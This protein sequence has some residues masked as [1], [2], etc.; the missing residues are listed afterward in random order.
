[1]LTRLGV[2]AKRPKTSI[3]P[4]FTLTSAVE[5]KTFSCMASGLGAL[6]ISGTTRSVID[7]VSSIE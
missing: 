5:R 1:M 2:E 7:S 4:Q 6:L 3:E